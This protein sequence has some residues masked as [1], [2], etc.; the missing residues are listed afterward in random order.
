[1]YLSIY[2]ILLDWKLDH[3]QIICNSLPETTDVADNF[4]D[5]GMLLGQERLTCFHFVN[6]T[7]WLK[8]YIA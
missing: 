8:K 3:I 1:M 7:C 5:G 2:F 6:Y 4:G